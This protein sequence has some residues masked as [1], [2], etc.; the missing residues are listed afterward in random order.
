[1]KHFSIGN[2]SVLGKE[3]K[4]DL[5]EL[6]GGWRIWWGVLSELILGPLGE[7]L[8]PLCAHKA[9]SYGP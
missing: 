8:G 2:V 9:S 7:P 4:I 6:G 1:M 5:S 3:L